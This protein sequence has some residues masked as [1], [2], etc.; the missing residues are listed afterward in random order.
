MAL[1][2]HRGKK[3]PGAILV[4]ALGALIFALMMSSSEPGVSGS[5]DATTVP[6]LS[7]VPNPT[8]TPAPTK[9]PIPT[10]TPTP[11]L[12]VSITQ[13]KQEY[14]ANQIAADQQY[15]GQMMRVTG[16]TIENISRDIFGSPYVSLGVNGG[17]DFWSLICRFKDENAVVELARGQRVGIQGTN[18]GMSLGS[19]EFKDC[20]LIEPSNFQHAPPPSTGGVEETKL[21]ITE[22]VNSGLNATELLGELNDARAFLNKYGGRVVVVTGFVVKNIGSTGDPENSYAVWLS[23]L[24]DTN[25]D[26]I[27]KC[28]ILNLDPI[29][30]EQ[31]KA[32]PRGATLTV[33]G[34]IVEV[35]DGIVVMKD[36]S[37]IPVV[38][39]LE[40]LESA[41][42]SADIEL[43]VAQLIAESSGDYL[44]ELPGL[45]KDVVDKVAL[46]TGIVE[47]HGSTEKISGGRVIRNRTLSLV[48]APGGWWVVQCSF[49][50]WS[51]DNP[52]L[53]KIE[54]GQS[55][56]V[57][58][59]ISRRY[60]SMIF[61]EECSMVSQ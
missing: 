16:A 8:K 46:I 13:L 50:P 12:T 36:C 38:P 47:T 59:V 11:I 61:V 53:D 18:E 29:E 39:K 40:S 25:L 45:N 21:P 57:K 31:I 3:K 9:T 60:L 2:T 35:R 48:A 5:P 1:I 58:G 43:T 41:R 37:I 54:V 17:F 34:M 10:P 20:I 56:T 23:N 7:V 44:A 6:G 32:I 24:P 19:V 52:V 14:D 30:I 22:P 15:K 49:S 42:A 55:A 33:K 28:Q 27:I 4:V 51:T 26:G